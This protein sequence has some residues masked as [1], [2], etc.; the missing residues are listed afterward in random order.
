V[1]KQPIKVLLVDDHEHVLWGLGKLIDGEWPS[2]TV[3]GAVKTFA[4]AR[5][6]ARE[7]TP[8]VIVL[9]V[10]L[11]DGN[12][13]DRLPELV[14]ECGAR[15]VVLTGSQESEV[16]HRALSAGAWAVLSKA[17]PAEVILREI[18]RANESRDAGMS[19]PAR[20]SLTEGVVMK[21]EAQSEETPHQTSGIFSSTTGE[22]S[23]KS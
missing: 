20:Q 8:D 23:W 13:I 21:L 3:V 9:D 17:Q 1:P 18:E 10:F 16:H 19:L 22:I 15:I 14:A 11:D 7:L 4:D 5:A 2:M 12:S 6:M